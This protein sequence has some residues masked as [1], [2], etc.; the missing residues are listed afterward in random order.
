MYAC[1]WICSSVS[2]Y[3]CV[4]DSAMSMQ[5]LCGN[6]LYKCPFIHLF[7]E[8]RG[9]QL[10]NTIETSLSLCF[11][12]I[13]SYHNRSRLYA[14]LRIC[15]SCFNHR[16][17]SYLVVFAVRLEFALKSQLFGNALYLGV[18]FVW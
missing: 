16:L 18:N 7:I 8:Q 11:F 2:M 14:I 9:L 3:V 17:G 10:G 12:M 4:N 15:I 6:A 13:S 1:T 5:L